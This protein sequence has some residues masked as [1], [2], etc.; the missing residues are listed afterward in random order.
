[1]QPGTD[2]RNICSPHEK[3]G[4]D[5]GCISAFGSE[6]AEEQLDFQRLKQ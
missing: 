4:E 3:V 5:V 6:D 1:M 2:K